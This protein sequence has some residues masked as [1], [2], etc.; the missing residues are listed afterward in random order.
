MTIRI[1]KN[2]ALRSLLTATERE[3]GYVAIAV[4][5]ADPESGEGNESQVGRIEC[6]A[7]DAFDGICSVLADEIPEGARRKVRVRR[8]DASGRK[9]ELLVRATHEPGTAAPPNESLKKAAA[10][11]ITSTAGAAPAVEPSRVEEPKPTIETASSWVF[12]T[13]DASPRPLPIVAAEPLPVDDRTR[14]HAELVRKEAEL[15]RKDADIAGS[16]AEIRA[17]RSNEES[18][19]D[20]A[21][22]AER[23]LDRALERRRED[24]VEHKEAVASLRLELGELVA[25]NET[26][27]EIVADRDAEIE[28]YE[29][30]AAQLAEQLE[31]LA[32]EVPRWGFGFG[33][34]R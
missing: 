15:A 4:V 17:M 25:A 7:I 3:E 11:P 10:V 14:L 26:L 24:R 32:D 31:E 33:R 28:V 2:R 19:R 6:P 23:R 13:A 30:D 27:S 21:R 22:A 16:A 18:L 5:E 34:R 1:N 8:Y 29:A 12:A 9:R 20:A